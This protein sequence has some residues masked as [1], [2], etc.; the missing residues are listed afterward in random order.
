MHRRIPALLA[1]LA[2]SLTAALVGTGSAAA[3]I[4]EPPTS[5]GDSQVDG[6]DG[7]GDP[8]PAPGSG[9]PDQP[10]CDQFTIEPCMSGPDGGGGGGGSDTQGPLGL[11]LPEVAERRIAFVRGLAEQLLYEK[12]KCFELLSPNDSRSPGTL[13]PIRVIN[14]V[15]IT[16]V[17]DRT[18]D[19]GFAPGL[20]VDGRIDILNGFFV[21]TFDPA[22]ERRG[23]I[24]RSKYFDLPVV[25]LSVL[26]MQIVALLHE[27][28]HLTG[29][30]VHP[31]DGRSPLLPE[32]TGQAF[33]TQIYVNCLDQ[34]AIYQ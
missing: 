10:S 29:V 24:D 3:S 25:E 19:L 13:N 34:G 28:G 8:A 5:T 32:E 18:L 6:P 33:N 20:G 2:L 9:N 30:N 17:N 11:P 31:N 14:T 7:G 22:F 23:Y 15:P 1:I 27:L 12:P 16:Y 26:D 21:I 4:L